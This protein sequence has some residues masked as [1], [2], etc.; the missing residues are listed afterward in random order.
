MFIQATLIAMVTGAEALWLAHRYVVGTPGERARVRREVEAYVLMWV[1]ASALYAL[2][3]NA[4]QIDSALASMILGLNQAEASVVTPD[5]SA[6][7]EGLMGLFREVSEAYTAYWTYITALRF[8]G[9]VGFSLIV[10]FTVNIGSIGSW[11]QSVTW[12]YS[13]GLQWM[14]LD[15]AF[16]YALWLI[17]RSLNT[18]WPLLIGLIIPRSTRPIGAS[19]TALW[20]V[21]TLSL[22]IL[23]TA[24]FKAVANYALF[25]PAVNTGISCLRNIQLGGTSTFTCILHQALSLSPGDW[26]NFVENLL[27]PISDAARLPQAGFML[28][29]WDALLDV[30]Y[31][32]ALLFSTWIGRLIDEGALAILP[33][34]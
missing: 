26:L 24:L 1:A 27:N 10:E 3:A 17:W 23:Y 9:S 25:S 22:P 21:L 15:I 4:H 8:I 18:A 34:P 32:L 28:M 5:A 6:V 33:T 20:I 14:M 31:A 2:Y 29:T 12:A 13:E 7:G 11:L 19:L 16:Q 30:G